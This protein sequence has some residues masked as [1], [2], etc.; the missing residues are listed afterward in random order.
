MALVT[1]ALLSP[2]WV[3]WIIGIKL[4]SEIAQRTSATL[5][6]GWVIYLPPYTVRVGGARLYLHDSAAGS[7]PILEI[8]KLRVSLAR[9]PLGTGPLLIGQLDITR[10]TLHLVHTS[11]G[12]SGGDIFNRF[13]PLTQGAHPKKLSDLFELRHVAVTDGKV[14][15]DDQTAATSPVIWEHLSTELK[16]TPMSPSTYHYEFTAHDAPLVEIAAAGRIDIDSLLLDVSSLVLDLQTAPAVPAKQLPTQVQEIFRQFAV[17]GHVN[18]TAAAR[19]PLTDPARGIFTS[20]FRL[21]SG[22]A[23]IPDWNAPIKPVQLSIDCFKLADNQSAP[24]ATLPTTLPTQSTDIRFHLN[25]FLLQCDNQTIKLDAGDARF[26]PS[27]QTWALGNVTGLVYVGDG[28]GPVRDVD[29]PAYLPVNVDGFGQFSPQNSMTLHIAVDKGSV[30]AA[31]QKIPFDQIDTVLTLTK[32]R[33]TTPRLTALTE[34]G[35]LSLGGF[36]DWANDFK[37]VGVGSVT[38]INMRKLADTFIAIPADRQKISGAGDLRAQFRGGLNADD[39]A[40]VGDLDVRHGHFYAVPILKKVLGRTRHGDAATVGE[41]A[42]TFYITHGNIEFPWL[43]A[44]SPLVGVQGNGRITFDD[45][46]DMTLSVA[47]MDDWRKSVQETDIPVLSNILGFLAGDAEKATN[48]LVREAVDQ[49][50]VTGKAD[51]PEIVQVPIPILTDAVRSLFHT[52]SLS[53]AEDAIIKELR[54]R[55][56]AEAATQQSQ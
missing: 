18:I 22:S 1:V 27:D 28:P 39:F 29:M 40:A 26:T 54:R 6:T 34:D 51:D 37:Y 45:K 25:Q 33:I 5:R 9:L 10:P 20:Q 53:K 16:T 7:I 3:G 56:S 41:I 38:D 42:G 50:R 31:P 46:I 23:H 48:D 35:Q 13:T 32:T 4:R 49:F 55:Q 30:R 52:M 11:A 21:T 43:A 19:V 44:N 24:P 2:L 15:Y 14:Q 36:I 12:M 47:A 17:A 8:A